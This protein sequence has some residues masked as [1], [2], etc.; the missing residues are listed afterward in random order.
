ML[1]IEGIKNGKPGLKVLNP[2]FVHSDNGKYMPEVKK[3]FGSD[4]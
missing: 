3:M 2:L 1:L 4:Y